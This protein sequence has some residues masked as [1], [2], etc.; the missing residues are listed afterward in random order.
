MQH[1]QEKKGHTQ[2]GAGGIQRETSAGEIK[3]REQIE[4]IREGHTSGGYIDTEALHDEEKKLHAILLT[5]LEAA[6]KE[7]DRAAIKSITREIN[8]LAFR[9]RLVV[10]ND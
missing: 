4:S 6:E 10:A 9:P 7:N 8:G 3:I 5:K 2:S 1:G